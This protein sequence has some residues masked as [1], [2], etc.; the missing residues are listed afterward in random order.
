VDDDL[1]RAYASRL[2]L[3]GAAKAA[4]KRETLDAL[5]AV[6]HVDRVAFR[7]KS[8][9]SFV[10]KALDPANDPPFSQPL[11][12]VEDQIAGRVIVFF[13]RDMT[14]VQER[15]GRTFSTVERSR[16]QPARDEEFGYESDHMICIIPPHLKPVGW[17][18]HASMPNTF[19]LQIRTIFMH[20][21][22]EPQHDVAYKSS[23]ELP[24]TVRRELAWIA[25]S[26]WGA[27]RAYQRV[28]EWHQ[29]TQQGRLADAE[30]RGPANAPAVRP[31]NQP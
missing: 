12:E 28:Q 8:V 2:P 18:E 15:L 1:R 30:E 17:A 20:A 31:P 19:E 6:E 25:A 4:L 7:V 29:A 10:A 3:L 11:L 16:R 14:T 26:A 21:Y 27:D 13:L 24:R 9:A 23:G 22:A 5:A